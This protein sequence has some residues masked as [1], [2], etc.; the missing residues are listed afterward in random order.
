MTWSDTAWNEAVRSCVRAGLASVYA[1]SRVVI[2]KVSSLSTSSF[3]CSRGLEKVAGALEKVAG[4]LEKV[5]GAARN[6]FAQPEEKTVVFI[7]K[8]C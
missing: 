6:N 5:A 3:Q 7:E 4:A 8:G 1:Y 2:L